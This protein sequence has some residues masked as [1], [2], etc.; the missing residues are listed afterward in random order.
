MLIEPGQRY[1]VLNN[2]KLTS[3][4]KPL[5]IKSSHEEKLL[6]ACNNAMCTGYCAGQ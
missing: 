1:N 4:T 2:L 5:K 3:K 6:M